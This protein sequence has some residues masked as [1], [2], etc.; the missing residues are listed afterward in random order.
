MRRDL[1][2]CPVQRGRATT[3]V[4]TGSGEAV[5]QARDHARELLTSDGRAVA[6]AA[7]RDSLLVVSELVTNA[8]VHAPGPCIL[9]VWYHDGALAITV[10]DTSPVLPVPRVPDPATADGGFGWQLLT[11][12]TSRIDVQPHTDGGKSVTAVL[13]AG[14]PRKGT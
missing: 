10:H 6:P 13:R 4:L 7:L 2:R 12:L 8:V 5:A 1:D 3:W 14:R 11:S 9:H